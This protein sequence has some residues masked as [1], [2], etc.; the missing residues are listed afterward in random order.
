LPSW[1]LAL[2][3]ER[4]ATA[5]IKSYSEGVLAYLRWCEKTGSS[6]EL[7]KPTVQTFIA[8]LLD[9][10]AQPKTA[11]ARLIA[12]RRFSAWLTDEG[13]LERDPLVGVKQ[14]KIDLK[15]VHPLSDDQL[16]AL[17]KACEGKSFIDRRDDAIVRLLMETGMRA[18]EVIGLQ[19]VDVD[20]KRRSGATDARQR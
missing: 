19:V 15:V 3:A 7:F 2:R 12:L 1:T 20:L 8:D 10:G 13:E 5:T 18:G 4:K 16:R 14:P 17:I 11:S 9:S 6:A